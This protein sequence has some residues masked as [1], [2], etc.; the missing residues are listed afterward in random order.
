[1]SRLSLRTIVGA[2]AAVALLLVVAAAAFFGRRTSLEDIDRRLRA[3]I[4]TGASYARVASV[5]DS[6]G[7]E[8]SG[9]NEARREMRA[10]WRRAAVG[11]T[12]ETAIEALFLFD[13]KGNLMRYELKEKISAV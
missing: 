6:L 5:L 2:V 4:G 3:D 12:Q 1:M 7:V 8:R 10:V 9:Y 13:E 11:L